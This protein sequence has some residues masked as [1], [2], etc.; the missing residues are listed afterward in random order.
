M[1]RLQL[2]AHLCRKEKGRRLIMEYT[3]KKIDGEL[4]YHGV[5]VDVFLD[6]AELNNGAVVRREVVDHPG[7]VAVIPVDDEGYCYMVRQ[8]RYP[9]QK[10]LLEVPAGKLEKGEDP[11]EC[12]I[13]ELGEETGFSADEIVSL[14]RDLTS[15]GFSNE[16]LY[17]FEARGL[18]KGCAH[19]DENEFLNVEKIH[20]DE[21]KK[22]VMNNEIEDGKTAICILKVAMKQ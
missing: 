6:H 7:G 8:Y 14:G 19:P 16:I 4:K 20:I 2:A 10:N 15:P 11:L 12:A 21:L 5:I 13:R 18:H 9:M 1:Q 3:E 17:L 22:M